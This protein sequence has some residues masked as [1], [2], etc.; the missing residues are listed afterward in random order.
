[1]A[2]SLCASSIRCAYVAFDRGEFPFTRSGSYDGVWQGTLLVDKADA[3]GTYYRR[4]R[5]YDPSTGRFT[6]E[7]PLGLAGGLNVYGFNG[8]DPVNFS[9][10]FG[11][12]PCCVGVVAVGGTEDGIVAGFAAGGPVGWFI[13]ATIVAALV[14]PGNE[15][16]PV[17]AAEAARS[18]A[19]DA[20]AV[21]SVNK[22][23]PK[24]QVV[25]EW[26][27][28]TGNGWPNDPATGKPMEA[29][30]DKPLADGGSDTGDNVTPRTHTDH[31]NR[32]RENGDFGR[33]ARRKGTGKTEPPPV[34][35]PPEPRI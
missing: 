17:T 27:N 16:G 3:T 2:D 7:D 21:S 1:G 18:P 5:S 4:N 34:E 29:D 25:R 9:D 30:H 10:P 12:T 19:A 31:V 15:P 28:K 13:D 11:L 22:R 35:K 24:H 14:L 23:R 32:H 6:Q 8:G 33:W 20:T 26:E